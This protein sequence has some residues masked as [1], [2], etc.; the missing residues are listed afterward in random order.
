MNR[1]KEICKRY[2][3]NYRELGVA[4]GYGYEAISKAGGTGIISSPMSKSIDMFIEIQDLKDKINL[5]NKGLENDKT[6]AYD[7]LKAVLKKFI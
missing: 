3:L 5:L 6:L 7:E 4:L 1:V 2:N